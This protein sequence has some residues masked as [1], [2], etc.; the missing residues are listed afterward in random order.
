MAAATAV[1]G[2]PTSRPGWVVAADAPLPKPVSR[3]WARGCGPSPPTAP[4]L[5]SSSSART[6]QTRMVRSS[7]QLATSVAPAAGGT[8]GSVGRDGDA[9][10]RAL[11]AAEDGEDVAGAVLGSL[12]LGEPALPDDDVAK[13]GAAHGQDAVAGEPGSGCRVEDG[14]GG[15][16]RRLE[17]QATAGGDAEGAHLVV[18][19]DDDAAARVEGREGAIVDPVCRLGLRPGRRGGRGWACAAHQRL[20]PRLRKHRQRLGAPDEHLT[21]GL[22]GGALRGNVD[23]VDYVDVQRAKAAAE[24]GVAG[25]VDVDVAVLAGEEIEAAVGRREEGEGRHGAQ[26]EILLLSQ[27]G[28]ARRVHSRHRL[29]GRPV[30][31]PVNS[32]NSRSCP[33]V[34]LAARGATLIWMNYNGIGPMTLTSAPLT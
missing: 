11:V 14:A 20:E 24:P 12:L 3:A 10:D 19:G 9:E 22:A 17:H 34:R 7:L 23:A 1:R 13:D 4:D 25:A 5:S 27:P 31:H 33:T 18:G 32:S 6:A 15:G 29:G 26:D 8:R 30:S 21:A 28:R 2:T 16:P